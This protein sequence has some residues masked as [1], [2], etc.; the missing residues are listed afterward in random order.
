[1][2][3]L[4]RIGGK[5]GTT[6]P[7]REKD[8]LQK[9]MNYYKN[10]KPS[11]RNYALTVLGLRT[12]LRISDILQLQWKDVYNFN[13]NCFQT[14]IHLTEQKTGKR[15][16]IAL[17]QQVILALSAFKE[18]RAIKSTDYIFTKSTDYTKPLNRSQAFRIVRKAAGNTLHLDHIS[19]HS[20]RK[21]FGYH[22]WKQGT[23]PALLMDIYNH[24]S[25]QVTKKYLGIEQDERD[26]IFLKLEL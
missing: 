12:A 25:Y 9:F 2:P 16:T 22:A 24:S 21:T 15:T 18:T 11:A 3:F 7:I 14:H 1:M 13:Q 17:N 20:L 5:M 23:P 19:C 8:E 26:D 6:E 10:E 4:R